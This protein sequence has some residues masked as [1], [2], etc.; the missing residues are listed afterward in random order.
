MKKINAF[1]SK[2]RENKPSEPKNRIWDPK[3]VMSRDMTIDRKFYTKQGKIYFGEN[4]TSGH[5]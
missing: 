4:K 2:K 3:S 5:K 1:M